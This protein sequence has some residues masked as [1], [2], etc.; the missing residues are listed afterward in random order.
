MA[1]TSNNNINIELRFNPKGGGMV[2]FNVKLPDFKGV[3]ELVDNFIGMYT[4]NNFLAKRISTTSDPKTGLKYYLKTGFTVIMPIKHGKNFSSPY[5]TWHPKLANILLKSLETTNQKYN[6]GLEISEKTLQDFQNSLNLIKG[7]LNITYNKNMIDILN[8]FF[9]HIHEPE[10]QKMLNSVSIVQF[11]NSSKEAEGIYDI[12]DVDYGSVKCVLAKTA[13]SVRNTLWILSQWYSYHKTGVPQMIAT[14][15]QWAAMGRMVVRS[16]PLLATKPIGTKQHGYGGVEQMV[17]M[18]KDQADSIDAGV[19]R[20]YDVLAKRIVGEGKY[21]GVIYY[22]ITDT[23]DMGNGVWAQYEQ[24]IMK[25][26]SN[27]KNFTH[28]FNDVAQSHMSDKEKNSLGQLQQKQDTSD[29]DAEIAKRKGAE[30]QFQDNSENAF[31]LRKAIGEL[32]YNKDN[33]GQITLNPKYKDT[34]VTLREMPNDFTAI[35]WSFYSHQDI[36]DRQKNAETRKKMIGLCVDMTEMLLNVSAVDVARKWNDVSKY[37]D[38]MNEFVAMSNVIGIVVNKVKD[39]ESNATMKEARIIKESA[40]FSFEDFLSILGETPTSLQKKLERK[41]TLKSEEQNI[42]ESFD[43]M[44]N[45]IIE[46]NKKNYDT[47]W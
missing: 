30:S 28:E 42:K 40:Y 21:S 10:V 23:A 8:N 19:S 2:Y 31:Y 12:G 37:F 3:K 43:S 20:T 35:L 1:I 32:I 4:K 13:L 14:Q 47:I 45:R 24:Q 26:G 16:Y 22:D 41:A 46:V 29:V 15:D 9:R 38:D 7:Q 34:A 39:L 27:M 18:T 11:T 44:W 36:L 17:G 6:L 5:R 33:Q 25:N